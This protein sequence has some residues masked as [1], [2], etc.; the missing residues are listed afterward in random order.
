MVEIDDDVCGTRDDAA[1][2]MRGSDCQGRTLNLGD[3]EVRR[4]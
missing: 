4:R 2:V 1:R 3:A